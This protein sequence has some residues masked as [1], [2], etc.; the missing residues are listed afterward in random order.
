[1]SSIGTNSLEMSASSV[2]VLYSLTTT[3]KP[4]TFNWAGP[5]HEHGDDSVSMLGDSGL[6]VCF[7]KDGIAFQRARLE[8]QRPRL[9]FPRATL[10]LHRARLEFQS[11]RL[12]FQRPR[13]EFQRPSL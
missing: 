13:L 6:K 1:M 12:E 3:R 9:E 8:F 5:C 4:D 11:P 2:T 7:H 10:E